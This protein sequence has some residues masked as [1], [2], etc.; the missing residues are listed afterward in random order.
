VGRP[1]GGRRIRVLRPDG[2]E[3]APREVGEVFLMPPGG[4]GSTYR[5][6]GAEA[7]ATRDGWETLGDMG[8]VDEEGFLYLVERKSDMILVGGANVYPAEIEAALEA[9]PAVRSSAVIGLP[10]DDLGSRVHAIVDAT[11]AVSA[12]ELRAHLEKQ[13]VAY[14][15]PRS[16]EFVSEPLRDDAGKLRRSALREARLAKQP[17]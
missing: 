10:D 9:H 7:T 5:Y 14:K 8:Y 11:A 13:L 4:Q 17:R 6:I 1:T 16:F 15:I 12:E 2:T 3:C